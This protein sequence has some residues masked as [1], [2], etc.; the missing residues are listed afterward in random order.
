MNEIPQS[1]SELESHLR[2]QLGFLKTS[3]FLF[4]LGDLAEAKRIATSIRVLLHNT[5]NSHSL[6]DQL[7]LKNISFLNTSL[8]YNS[9]NKKFFF[10]MCNVE[11]ELNDDKVLIGRC[12]PFLGNIP[13]GVNCKKLLF[14]KWWNQVVIADSKNNAFSRMELILSLANKD[15][16]AHVDPALPARYRALTREN[17]LGF[18]VGTNGVNTPIIGF[19]LATVRQIAYELVGSIKDKKPE[20]FL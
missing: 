20:Y 6:L 2:E 19:E 7:N 17:S 16:G 13:K 4:D 9:R 3:A 11:I 18:S 14:S 15:G 5:R 1:K 8:E 10:G 12:A